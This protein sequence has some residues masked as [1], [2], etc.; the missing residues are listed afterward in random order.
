MV[1]QSLQKEILDQLDKLH[2]EQQRQVLDFARVLA[3][4]VGKHGKELLHFAGDIKLEDLR[5]ISQAIEQ[6]CE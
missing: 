5:L 4:P 1:N 2:I 3:G 6:D